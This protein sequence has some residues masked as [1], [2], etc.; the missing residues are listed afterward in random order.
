VNT[1]ARWRNDA[2]AVSADPCRYDG[3]D[4]RFLAGHGRQP[5]GRSTRRN[6][7]KLTSMS[8]RRWLRG[9]VC[10]GIAL[11]GAVLVAQ[12]AD[13]YTKASNNSCNEVRWTSEQPR[14]RIHYEEFFAGGGD[15]WGL[16]DLHRAAWEVISEFNKIGG[17]TAEVVD[18]GMVTS[19]D[20]FEAGD[21][22]PEE[23]DASGDPIPTI[24]IGFTDDPYEISASGT[25][26]GAAQY[27]IDGTTCTYSQVHIVFRDMNLVDWNFGTP[28]DSGKDYYTAEASDET[29]IYFR[30]AFLHELIHAFGLTH[31]DDT[32][33][34]MNYGQWPWAGGGRD[35]TEAIRPLPDDI[36]GL[37]YLYPGSGTRSEVAV[38]NTWY[39]ES[40]DPEEPAIQNGICAPSLGDT[41]ST[42]FYTYE[43][44][45][46]GPDAGSTEVCAD[47]RLFTRYT[48][49]NYSTE[50]ADSIDVRLFFSTDDTYQS[51]DLGSPTHRDVTVASAHSIMYKTTWRVPSGLVSGQ[52]YYV[53]VYVVGTTTSGGWVED[54]I[55]L[56]GTVTGC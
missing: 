39:T 3:V 46:G 24:H 29:G 2:D 51:T 43:C 23:L 4:T 8:G 22:Y 52:E 44:G 16:V 56:T 10:T 45:D 25:G 17:T 35:E 54:W 48:F 7:V 53:I 14:Y 50:A 20:A 41:F 42:F 27:H 33:A 18:D 9:V 15:A 13:A 38:L 19:R 6:D 34:F 55:P 26:T 1:P 47:D 21:W 40:G 11:A 32:Y 36:R 31:S 37:R 30:P 5:G 49:A 12:P 28:S